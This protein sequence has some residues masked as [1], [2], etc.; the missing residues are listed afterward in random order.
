MTFLFCVF[1]PL[2]ILRA[3]DARNNA[4]SPY[5]PLGNLVLT[6]IICFTLATLIWKFLLEHMALEMY[7]VPAWAK[8]SIKYLFPWLRHQ[9][10]HKVL[11]PKAEMRAAKLRAQLG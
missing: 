3:W 2:L 9:F 6:L 11:K 7:H 1:I 5:G 10:D 4:D 8:S